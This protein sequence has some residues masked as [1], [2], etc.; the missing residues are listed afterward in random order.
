MPK[1]EEKQVVINEIKEKLKKAASA[2]L[3]DARGLTV[4]EDTAF[5]KNLREAGVEYKVYKN[6]MM[7]FA[8]KDTPFEGLTEYLAGPSAIAVSYGDALL[9]AKI[10]SREQKNIPN[11]QFKAGVVENEV[12]NETEIL[13]LS[14]IPSREELLS[15]LLGSL[16]SPMSSFARLI[17]AVAEKTETPEAV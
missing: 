13:A 8:F 2:I 14:Q 1:I 9:A 6:T 10:I 16:K 15:R 4:A 17:N 5:R 12:Y 11:L 7:R 3:I